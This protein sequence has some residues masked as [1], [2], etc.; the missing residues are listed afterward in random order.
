MTEARQPRVLVADDEDAIRGVECFD[1][2]GRTRRFFGPT[3][4]EWYLALLAR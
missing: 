1:D 2:F 3:L 4:S